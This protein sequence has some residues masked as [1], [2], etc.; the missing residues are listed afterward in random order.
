MGFKD[1]KR[2][3]MRNC[4]AGEEYKN[5]PLR[6]AYTQLPEWEAQAKR[7]T[8]DGIPVP[9]GRR[10]N[11]FLIG[12]DPEFVFSFNGAPKHAVDL[13][14]KVG[15]AAG[16]DQN[17]RLVEL[18]PY[19]STSVVAHVAGIMTALRW[20]FRVYY[21]TW[22]TMWRAGAF[23]G[24]DGIGGHVHFGRKS[25]LREDEVRAL[26]ALALCLGATHM[27]P[28][29]EW[30][31]RVLGDQRGQRYGQLSDT[32]KQ[33]HGYEYR[34]L[35]SW[36]ISPS[37]AFTVLTLSKLA[38]LD[39]ELVI[40]WYKTATLVQGLEH[41]IMLAKYYKGRDDDALILFKMLMLERER[42]TIFGKQYDVDFR[43]AWGIPIAQL[44]V[45]NCTSYILPSTIKPEPGEI[46]E[47]FNHLW[48]G[49]PLT[50][51]EVPPNFKHTIPDG[52]RWLPHFV[53]AARRSG[54]GDFIHDLVHQGEH[55]VDLVFDEPGDKILIGPTWH[56]NW[57][58]EELDRVKQYPWVKLQSEP[59][60]YVAVPKA[61]RSGEAMAMAKRVLVDSGLLPLWTVE[62]VAPDSWDVWRTQ[63]RNNVK[64]KKVVSGKVRQL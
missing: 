6:E 15:I 24:G 32:R 1:V 50:F 30:R 23:Y 7:L 11:N 51:A 31:T 62:K 52:Y 47:M 12:S 58:Q 22:P 59:G 55:P 26:D 37:V 21:H 14:L 13:G 39:P 5:A 33:K 19:P 18:R 27:F 29:D 48:G 25:S 49:A 44:L 41:F 54:V 36:L 64:E 43:P 63:H 60:R 57:S 53:R 20:L 40:P 2:E 45:T 34:T 16:C 56:S 46:A 61:W 42:H 9:H 10:L 3:V 4:V 38:L 35:P 28:L 8:L 17:E